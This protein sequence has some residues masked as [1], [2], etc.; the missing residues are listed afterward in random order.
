MEG[1][2]EKENRLMDMDNSVLIAGGGRKKG[3]KRTKL[4]HGLTTYTQLSQNELRT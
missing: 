3:N 2:S 4:D 1:W